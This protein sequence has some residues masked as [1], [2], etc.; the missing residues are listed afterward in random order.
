MDPQHLLQ[1][2]AN[3]PLH[4]IASNGISSEEHHDH[5][6]PPRA[7][8]GQNPQQPSVQLNILKA[9][10]GYLPFILLLIVKNFYSHRLGER[11]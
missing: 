8:G 5:A 10:E 1:Q 11:T 9:L 4:S 3:A 6:P 2:I 7:V